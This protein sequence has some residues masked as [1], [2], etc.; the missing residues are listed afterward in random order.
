ERAAPPRVEGEVVLGLRA[1]LAVFAQRP[2]DILRVGYG[3][4]VRNEVETL[5]R[6]ALARRI[7]CGE[8]SEGEL[9]RIAESEHHEGLCVLARE[10]R[11]ATAQELGDMLVKRSGT[12]IALDR[13]RNP[14]NIGAIVRSAAFFGVDAA[15]LGTPA[16]HPGLPPTAVRVAEGGAEHLALARTT[17]LADTL[18]RLRAK[19]VR[20]VGADG[21]ADRN[22][23]GFSFGRPTIL[24]LGNEREGLGDRVRATCDAIVGIPGSGAVESLNVA[25]AAGVLIAELSRR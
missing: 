10:R 2:S 5:V 17:D 24:V 7:P 6:W 4:I 14:Y 22:A 12:A 21:H 19:K 13:V 23:V 1:G 18:T 3:R 8:L 11:W 20:V 15:L 25:V 9:A 16:P